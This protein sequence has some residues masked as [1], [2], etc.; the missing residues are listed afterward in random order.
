MNKEEIFKAI[1]EALSKAIT[2]FDKSS[3]D[4]NT[5]LIEEGVLDSLDSMVFLME[6]SELTQ[7]DFPDD[8]LVDQGLFKIGKLITFIQNA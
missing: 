8:D 6:L 4:E 1:I 2:N 5:D 3:V 7:V